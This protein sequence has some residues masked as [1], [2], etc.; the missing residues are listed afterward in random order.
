MLLS[1]ASPQ[2]WLAMVREIQRERPGARKR[3]KIGLGL[4]GERE[5]EREKERERERE[6]WG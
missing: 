2:L 5:R 6:S 4:G 1:T 3:E